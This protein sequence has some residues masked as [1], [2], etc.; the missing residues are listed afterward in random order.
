LVTD[1][2]GCAAIYIN[3]NAPS[4]LNGTPLFNANSTHYNGIY[5][6]WAFSPTRDDVS[7]NI[8]FKPDTGNFNP[9][10]AANAALL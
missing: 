1:N 8:D 2:N 7:L 6:F 4:A 5:N 9:V 10:L 3:P